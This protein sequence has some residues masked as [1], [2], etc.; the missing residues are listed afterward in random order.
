[1]DKSQNAHKS[2]AEARRERI[3]QERAERVAQVNAL[4][5]IRDDPKATA[6]ERL[7]AV[8]LLLELEK[9]WYLC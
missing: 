9:E 7:E 8:K 3:E 4:R 1:M 5:K 6:G 2:S